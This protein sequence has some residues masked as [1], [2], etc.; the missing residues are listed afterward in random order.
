MP[1]IVVVWMSCDRFATV[2]GKGADDDP[3]RDET[4]N[5]ILKWDGSDWKVTTE[6]TTVRRGLGSG[7]VRG[8]GWTLAGWDGVLI[9][10][11]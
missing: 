2:R 5:L 6:S 10:E 8:R 3:L 9:H 4:A 1:P 11:R 7:V